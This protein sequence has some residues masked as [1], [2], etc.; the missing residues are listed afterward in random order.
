MMS[1]VPYTYGL[2][3]PLFRGID[4]TSAR[5]MLTFFIG[6]GLFTI[7]RTESNVCIEY[8]NKLIGYYYEAEVYKLR[9]TADFTPTNVLQI[10]LARTW[11]FLFSVLFVSNSV[12]LLVLSISSFQIVLTVFGA[13]ARVLGSLS[14][15]SLILYP[16]FGTFLLIT[17]IIQFARS[18]G[19][20]TTDIALFNAGVTAFLLAQILPFEGC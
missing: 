6:W 7:G 8:N 19:H 14:F 11:V 18:R 12:L 17:V 10:C 20:S 1:L 5:R 2:A 15:F 16:T 13:Q 9:I 3:V 4:F